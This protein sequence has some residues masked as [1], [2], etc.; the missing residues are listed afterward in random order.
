MMPKVYRNFKYQNIIPTKLVRQ[1]QHH[2]KLDNLK[3]MVYL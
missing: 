1:N 3:R 2:F